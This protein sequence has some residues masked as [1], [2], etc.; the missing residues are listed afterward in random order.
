MIV[1][2]DKQ[3]LPLSR[4]SLAPGGSVF[5]AWMQLSRSGEHPAV[6]TSARL[7]DEQSLNARGIRECLPV[8]LRSGNVYSNLARSD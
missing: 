5:E 1:D 8:E 3:G 4:G 2:V 6:V 7:H